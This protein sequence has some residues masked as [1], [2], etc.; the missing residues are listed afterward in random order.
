MKLYILLHSVMLCAMLCSLTGCS[1][2]MGEEDIAFPHL[3]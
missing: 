1:E 3:I 2:E